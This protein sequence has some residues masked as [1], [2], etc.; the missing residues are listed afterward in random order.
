MNLIFK[1]A[2]PKLLM[3]SLVLAFV[4]VSAPKAHAAADITI[5]SATVTSSTTVVVSF[6][7][8]GASLT[9]VTAAKWHI[10][11]TTGGVSPLD[12]TS[13]VVTSATAPWTVTLTF[14]AGSFTSTSTSYDASHGLYAEASAVTDGTDTNA[15][16]GHAASV[17]ILDGQKP[18]FTAN[19]TA[20]NTIVLTYSESV[21]ETAILNS[22]TVAGASAVTN[23]AVVAGTS[24]TLT[25]TGLTS[26]SSTPAVGYVAATGDVA[27]ASTNET[28]N[29]GAISATDHVAPTLA[30]TL[31]DNDLGHGEDMTITFTFSEVPTGFT[32]ADVTAPN[33]T[34][35]DIDTTNPLVQTA[36]FTPDT[37]SS[38]NVITVGTGWTDSSVALN[39]PA[40]SNTSAA[41]AIDTHTSGGG[42]GGGGSSHSSTSATPAVPAN[43]STP[44]DCT[45]GV[46][47]SPTTGKNCNAA[48]PATPN[49]QGNV[50]AF[51]QSTVKMGAKGDACKAWQM[52]FNAHGSN[53][54]T[55]GWCG[56]MTIASAKAWQMSVGL[57]A[58]GMLGAMSRAKAMMQ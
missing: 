2:L 27:D 35:G 14:A 15:V 5:L 18:T 46:M 1:K 50:Y 11:Q 19:R 53:L 17:A 51:G 32:S 44:S 8:P 6:N 33:G 54:V 57:M 56:K 38:G 45:A 9:A 28:A 40:G 55:D 37:S 12:P 47:F 7:D 39:A 43:E 21:T 10:D 41:Y 26:T 52:F 30:I 49:A 36:L 13:A 31:S 42:G 23:S 22:Y 16:V 25:T 4:F 29:G 3:A 58:D 34:L 20:L 24:V 48:T